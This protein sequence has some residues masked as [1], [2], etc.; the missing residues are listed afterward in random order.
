MQSAD[1]VEER[2]PVDETLFSFFSAVLT[3]RLPEQVHRII[4]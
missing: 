4:A 3:A 1:V 2:L